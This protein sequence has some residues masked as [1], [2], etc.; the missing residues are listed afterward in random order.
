MQRNRSPARITEDIFN[1]AFDE[2]FN[3][4]VGAVRH[5]FRFVLFDFFRLIVK[6]GH[7]VL[8]RMK[9]EWDSF[10]QRSARDMGTVSSVNRLI[11][12]L[13]FPILARAENAWL[14]F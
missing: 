13:S 14:A 12:I 10:P 3:D 6:L 5:T 7:D 4:D 9:V 8:H 2:R 1:A 11:R